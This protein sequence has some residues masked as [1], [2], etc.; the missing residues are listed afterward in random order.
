MVIIGG[1]VIEVDPN[2]YDKLGIRTLIVNGL[3]ILFVYGLGLAVFPKLVFLKF[4]KSQK[5]KSIKHNEAIT[6]LEKGNKN[7]LKRKS[8]ERKSKVNR[9]DLPVININSVFNGN[10]QKTESVNNLDP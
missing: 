6:A 4:H 7:K 10:V 1:F 2:S 5:M 8:S 9:G 3:V